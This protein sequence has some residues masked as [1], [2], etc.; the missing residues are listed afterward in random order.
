MFLSAVSNKRLS[1]EKDLAHESP[2]T[3][4]LRRAEW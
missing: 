3:E 2:Y 4:G 1:L